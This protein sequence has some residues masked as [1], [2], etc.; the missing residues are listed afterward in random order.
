VRS[1]DGLGELASLSD[2]LAHVLRVQSLMSYKVG[3]GKR[4]II[5]RT[6]V[7]TCIH[8]DI[9]QPPHLVVP[10]QHRGARRLGLVLHMLQFL[11]RGRPGLLEVYALASRLDA[12]PQQARVVGRPSGD[13][14]HAR[15]LRLR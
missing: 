9:S 13:E 8:P 2:V 14:G 15:L 5:T 10:H 7:S 1:L 3:K 4:Q 11:D 6:I 12:L